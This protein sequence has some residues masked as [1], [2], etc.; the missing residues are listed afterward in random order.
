[1]QSLS[2]IVRQK[3]DHARLDELLQ[4]LEESRR[5]QE[6][7]LLR[8]IY[9]LVF[10]HAFAEEGVL[11]PVMRRVLP[12]GQ[13]LTLEVEQEHQE[14]NELVAQID[15]LPAGDPER[16]ARIRRLVE[17][18][19]EDVHDEEDVLLPRL[20]SRL[21]DRQLQALGLAWEV[22]RRTAPTRAHPV[23]SRRP[24][25]NTTS[26]LPLSII[27]RSRDRLDA[28][29]SRGTRPQAARSASQRLGTL[30]TRLEHVPL[31]T[32]GEDPSTS[33]T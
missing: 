12:D 19:K 6:D 8:E 10:P 18:L 27:D 24:P 1:M 17:V 25:G 7:D 15:R 3:R 14:V 21:S 4:Q 32:R 33:R 5:H 9:R 11:W 31:F 16:D 13:A 22:V 30:A 29:A 2:V 26:A 20:E 28:M 23:V